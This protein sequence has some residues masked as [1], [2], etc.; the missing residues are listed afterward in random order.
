MN[1]QQIAAAMQRARTALQRRPQ[2]GVHDDSLAT[3]RWDGG[4]RVVSHHADGMQLA[5]DM[6][7]ELGG[8]GDAPTPGWFLRAG[9][10]SCAATRIAIAAAEAGIELTALEVRASSRSDLRGLLGMADADGEPV[11]AGPL[12]VQLVV[13]IAAPGVAPER[14]RQLVE[15]SDRCSPVSDALR[16]ALRVDLR[17]DLDPS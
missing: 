11:P 3:S 17:V 15:T 9:L 7:V 14:L 1:Q 10:A 2:V 12:E 6:P 8:A 5:T 13:R 4:T 16:S